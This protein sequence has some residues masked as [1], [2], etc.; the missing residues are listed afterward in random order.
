MKVDAP[1]HFCF[2]RFGLEPKHLQFKKQAQPSLPM[3]VV[4]RTHAAVTCKSPSV[5]V[6]YKWAWEGETAVAIRMP[7]KLKAYFLNLL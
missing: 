5:C 2:S 3:W 1:Q 6:G 7:M 4:I